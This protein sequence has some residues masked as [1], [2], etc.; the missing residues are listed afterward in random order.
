MKPV[1]VVVLSKFAD[2]FQGFRESV[3]RFLP[4][5][6]RVL[7]RDGEEIVWKAPMT[8]KTGFK[9]TGFKKRY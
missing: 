4:E 5:V 9:K 2:I 6:P 7:V 3:D 1:T 8:K